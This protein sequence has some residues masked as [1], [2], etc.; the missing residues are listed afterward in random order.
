MVLQALGT[1]RLRPFARRAYL[2]AV[3]L[4]SSTG[5][6]NGATPSSAR[7]GYFHSLHGGDSARFTDLVDRIGRHF[8]FVSYSKAV[9]DDAPS[10]FAWSIDD[11][12]GSCRLVGQLLAERGISACFFVSPILL[13]HRPGESVSEFFGSEHGVEDEVLDWRQA[14]DLLAMGHEI[15]SHTCHHLDLATVSAAQLHEEI[16][17]SREMLAERL[18]RIDHFAWPYGRFHHF[19]AEAY[20]VA[21]DAGY[22]SVASAE[23]HGPH[24]FGDW[25]DS[26]VRRDHLDPAWPQRHS[27]YFATR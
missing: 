24:R 1:S 26:C 13:G 11:G 6:R 16:C 23:R 10:T 14:E 27:V 20:A 22:S 12:F 5:L 8:E 9:A 21:L 4:L 15:G 3:S 7:H 17:G 19:T 25:R 2:D 18:G